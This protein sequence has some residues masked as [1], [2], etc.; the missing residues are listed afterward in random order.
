MDPQD[1]YFT[2]EEADRWFERNREALVPRDNDTILRVLDLYSLAPRSVLEVGAAN[3]Y[4]LAAIAE[5]HECRAVAVDPSPAALADGRSRYPAVEFHRGT[6]QSIPLAENFDLVIVNFVLH[7]IA[8]SSLSTAISEVD[9][10]VEKGGLL[11]IGD[12]LPSSPSRTPYHHRP[13]LPL[14][15]YKEDYAA[16]FLATGRYVLI[17]LLT[18]HFHR[19]LE[20]DVA[21]QDRAGTWLLRKLTHR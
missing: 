1:L 12:F 11:C 2:G 21:E 18:G 5:R 7:W 3:G 20:A 4:R 16:P 17:A 8:R 19:G 6:A 13:E 10:V 14:Y 9:R 15:T